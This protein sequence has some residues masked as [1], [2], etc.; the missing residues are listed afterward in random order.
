[1]NFVH[2]V[3]RLGADPDIHPYSD[4]HQPSDPNAPRRNL[5][6]FDLAVEQAWTPNASKD[7]PVDWIPV[8]IFDGPSARYAEKAIQKG[9]LI[10]LSGRIDTRRWTDGENRKRKDIRVVVIDLEKLG[11]GKASGPS[12]SGGQPLAAIAAQAGAPVSVVA[13]AGAMQ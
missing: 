10:S 7:R 2:L 13:K 9:D 11:A 6:R 8:V 1:M 4:D 5:V 3:G 12:G